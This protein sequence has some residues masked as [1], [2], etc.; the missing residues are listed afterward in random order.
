MRPYVHAVGWHTVISACHKPRHTLGDDKRLAGKILRD[1][2][3]PVLMIIVADDIESI[4]P[5]QII[6]G[7]RLVAS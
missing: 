5:E 1:I 4:R 3:E 6:V 2:L 7:I